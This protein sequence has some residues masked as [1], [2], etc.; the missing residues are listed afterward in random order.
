MHV[1]AKIHIPIG[2]RNNDGLNRTQPYRQRASMMFEQHTEKPLHASE[3]CP[4]D[5]VR[6]MRGAVLSDVGQVEPLRQIEIKLNCTELP[7]PSDGILH[8][9]ID[10]RAVKRAIGRVDLI[11]NS[12]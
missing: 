10:L 11:W 8:D 2:N 1:G 7:W 4:V 6:T 3:Q 5:H 12:R 9:Q